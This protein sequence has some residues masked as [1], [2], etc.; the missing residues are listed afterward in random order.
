LIPSGGSTPV[1]TKDVT[2]ETADPV[3]TTIVDNSSWIDLDDINAEGVANRTWVL[4]Q[5]G[6]DFWAV[7]AVT[8]S[9]VYTED[10]VTID[11]EDEAGVENWIVEY[12]GTK[13]F[14]LSAGEGED[15]LGYEDVVSLT[16]D[17]GT[18]KKN[19]EFA[20]LCDLQL[21]AEASSEEKAFALDG[22][23]YGMAALGVDEAI[24]K[25][26]ITIVDKYGEFFDIPSANELEYKSSTGQSMDLFG[27]RYYFRGDHSV[28]YTSDEYGDVTVYFTVQ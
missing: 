21:K 24:T 10:G 26:K 28:T 5:Y 11:A 4:D 27:T 2:F 18:V 15:A 17:Y 20:V 25:G 14:K 19:I 8:L 16:V 1:A 9:G 6:V 13:Y 12:D 3:A 23:R 7:P 22:G